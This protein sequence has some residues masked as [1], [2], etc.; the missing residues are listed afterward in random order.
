M[1]SATGSSPLV[2]SALEPSSLGSSPLYEMGDQ[3]YGR[4]VKLTSDNYSQ[5][6]V[7]V[8][9]V[10]AADGLLGVVDGT[11]KLTA[12]GSDAPKIAKWNQDDAKARHILRNAVDPV[13]H[14]HVSDCITSK[15][16]LDKI[17]RTR[18]PQTTNAMMAGLMDF[19]NASWKEDDDVTSFM[20]RLS[21]I[22][23]RVASSQKSPA[24]VKLDGNLIMARTLTSLPMKYQTFVQSW[25]LTSK[26]DSTLEDFTNQLLNAERL[27]AAE[28]PSEMS[29]GEAFGAKFKDHGRKDGKDRFR[30]QKMA[31]FT[32]KCYSCG[33]AGHKKEDCRKKPSDKKPS[34]TKSF[35]SKD[36]A[37]QMVAS[38]A[39][40]VVSDNMVLADSGASNHLTGNK[41]WFK[42]LR[43]MEKPHPYRAAGGMIHATQEGDIDVEISVDGLEWRP[44]LWT[45]VQYVKE[46]GDVTLFSPGVMAKK[47]FKFWLDDKNMHLEKDG[48]PFM[49]GKASGTTYIPYMRVLVPGT[50]LKAESVQLWHNRLGHVSDETIRVMESKGLVDGLH[51]DGSKR[52]VCTA[53]HLG[54][55]TISHHPKRKKPRDC[56]PGERI[57]S[58]V[59][60]VNVTSVTGFNHFL[61]FKDEASAFRKVHLIKSKDQVPEE[62]KRFVMDAERETGRKMV[63][64][65]SDNGT[66]FI[67]DFVAS[68]FKERGI[69]HER[70]P[71]YVKQANG[72]AERE[73]RTLC[74][75]ARSML[76]NTD[77]SKSVRDSL[78]S[79]AIASAT[80]IWN[81]V[82]NRGVTDATPYEKWFG[83]KPDVSHIRTFG[84]PAFVRIPDSQRKKLDDKSWEGIFVGY[85]S[86]TD[87]NYRVYDP[88][89]RKVKVVSDVIVEDGCLKSSIVLFPFSSI[90]KTDAC[91]A[92]PEVDDPVS[93]EDSYDTCVE[94][95]DGSDSTVVP[96]S[97]E[98]EEESSD[99]LLDEARNIFMDEQIEKPPVIK[100]G[101]GRPLGS[102]NGPK[103]MHVEHQMERRSKKMKLAAQ[104]VAL[105]PVSVEDALSRPD[106]TLW[107]EAMESEM[108][109]LRMNKT[110]ELV[111]LPHGSRPIT[112]RWVFKSKLNPDSSLF[113]R[114]ARLV[115]HGYRQKSGI[116]YEETFAPVVRHESVR[117][118][119][120][121]VAHHDMDM[122]Q[123]DVKT[124]FLNGHLDETIFMTQPDGYN[125][126]SGKVCHL[127]K[128]LYGLKQAP[129]NWHHTFE[130]F[131]MQDGFMSSDAD[132]CIFIKKSGKDIMYLSLYVD[133]GLLCST[134]KSL[135]DVFMEKLKKKFE[136]TVGDPKCYVGMEIVRDRK[137][138]T[139]CIRQPGYVKRMLEKFGLEDA[140]P[141][142]TPMEQNLKLLPGI[143]AE[144]EKPGHRFPY[145]E[146]IGCL[147]YLSTISRPDISFAV[148]KLASFTSCP[149]STHWTAVKENHA[150]P[151]GNCRS[152]SQLWWSWTGWIS[153]HT[154]MR[155]GE[156]KP[157]RTSLLRDSFSY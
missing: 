56:L 68:F 36:S 2:S 142:S 112:C 144:E 14:S 95:E 63:S 123:F 80:H 79:E 93:E 64:F 3:K 136:V 57:H 30:K 83:K 67:N 24:T 18:V 33:I 103:Q 76:R 99:E 85:D 1:S 26:T 113:K 118:L 41:H 72:M 62:I 7:D 97:S 127:L 94:D 52:D 125:D 69:Q 119:L 6:I 47:G 35:D 15:D 139:I 16:I 75:T 153:Q 102:K 12:C 27:H 104:A 59:C 141:A 17:V 140:T 5:W 28:K 96:S 108:E 9:D 150:L 106:G 101:P 32:G 13:T 60:A 133:D 50:A 151:E 122:V 156:V 88:G 58:D 39:L 110:W 146:A 74:D 149:T 111:E 38:S 61:V 129:R 19:F 21:I 132:H 152:W 8:K 120:A 91:F 70:S 71:P 53:C 124:A 46:M 130:T 126:G 73:N 134:N 22:A 154:V 77:L 107:K 20:A 54:K 65:R 109:S 40:S 51:T 34:E 116:D 92:E 84:A 90:D 42:T 121:L 23:S 82:I 98:E 25:Y 148:T 37:A 44:V 29:S 78:W 89:D 55:Q 48:Q 143:K 128:S 131:V 138:K 49:G 135:M 117:T 10:L 45:G 81:R 87:K 105:D 145:R 66:E 114:K 157:K 43:Q 100:R 86:L 115:V 11:D 155:T 147:I 31:K 137:K 4:I